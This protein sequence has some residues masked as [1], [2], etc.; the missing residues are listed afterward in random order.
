MTRTVCVVE[1]S[2]VRTRLDFWQS[3]TRSFFF[4]RRSKRESVTLSL[5]NPRDSE[6][7]E[8]F[9]VSFLSNSKFDVDFARFGIRELCTC[10][11]PWSH[12]P[13]SEANRKIKDEPSP[14]QR[15]FRGE[16]KRACIFERGQA[17]VRLS[18][19]MYK[20]F[21]RFENTFYRSYIL[22]KSRTHTRFSILPL[23]PRWIRS[24]FFTLHSSRRRVYCQLTLVKDS[25]VDIEPRRCVLLSSSM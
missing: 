1:E 11:H 14:L 13:R 22:N 25:K 23:I 15:E 4:L 17:R 21:E 18:L 16:K 3:S 2:L 12:I 19:H 5:A 8:T 24:K 20:F 7:L 9:W 6:V 10:P